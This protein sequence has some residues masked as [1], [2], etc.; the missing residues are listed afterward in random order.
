MSGI[1]IGARTGSPD[2]RGGQYSLF[3]NGVPY[4]SASIESAWIYGLQQNEENRSNLALVNTGEI[5]DS[6]IT[7]DITIYDG[8][9]DR[10]PRT[11][12]VTLGP[13]PMDSGKWDSGQYQSRVRSG[14][15]DF[16]Q[17]P[18]CHLRRDQ[19]RR[20]ARRTQ[21]RR[22]FPAQSGVAVPLRALFF[23]LDII[24]DKVCPRGL[25][26]PCR[27]LYRR[28]PRRQLDQKPGPGRP[29]A[30]LR[31]P[32]HPP[33][34]SIESF[35]VGPRPQARHLRRQDSRAF[36]PPGPGPARLDRH[37]S[38]R[39]PARSGSFGNPGLHRGPHRR[40]GPFAG[41]GTSRTRER[42]GF[43]GFGKREASSGRSPFA[44]T[45]TA[46]LESTSRR[47]GSRTPPKR[48]PCSA[49]PW[50]SR[51]SSPPGPCRPNPW[52]SCSSGGSRM[53]GCPRSSTPTV[54]ASW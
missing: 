26:R 33:C 13:P 5:D 50:A 32:G 4:G 16:R 7:L 10:Q 6:S 41:A 31:H 51:S 18:V 2:K 14:D 38:R 27:P 49:R 34:R 8:S 46:G 29:Q 30:F 20:Q 11:K 40:C 28:A 24:L 44:M 48:P 9:G 36:H 15:E 1:V 37:L 23:C 43:C 22:R 39:G 3:Y 54:S 47:Q 35:P 12:S 53:P 19:R 42:N 17:Q 21:R 45:S 25:P 52:A